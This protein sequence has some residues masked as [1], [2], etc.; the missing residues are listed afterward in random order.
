MAVAGCHLLAQQEQQVL[1]PLRG[2]MRSSPGLLRS[3][4]CMKSR[5]AARAHA[6]ISAG[7]PLPPECQSAG[8]VA[9]VPGAR[10][11]PLARAG[12]RVHQTTHRALLVVHQRDRDLV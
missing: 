12:G 4:V 1:I 10:P 3:D 8:A 2:P 7:V 5:S 11:W 9:P 6:A